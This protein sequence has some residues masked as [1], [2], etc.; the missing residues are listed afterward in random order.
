MSLL[1]INKLKLQRKRESLKPHYGSGGKWSA[2]LEAGSL[3][4]Y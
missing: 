4:F 2:E 1:H 3:L